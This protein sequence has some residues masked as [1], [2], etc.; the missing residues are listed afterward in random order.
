MARFSTNQNAYK[1]LLC[2]I[3]KKNNVEIENK[4][5]IEIVM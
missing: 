2:A 5:K 1:H 3:H 4:I